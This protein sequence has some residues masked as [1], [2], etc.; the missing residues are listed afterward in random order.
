MN[1]FH[2]KAW[3]NPATYMGRAY[4]TIPKVPIQKWKFAIISFGR[5]EYLEDDEVV[6]QRFR[7]HDNYGNWDDYLGLEHPQVPG[8]GRKKHTARTH[9]DKPVKIYG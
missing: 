6:K 3:V 8:T 7:K 5:V 9:H 1:S 4:N 2:I